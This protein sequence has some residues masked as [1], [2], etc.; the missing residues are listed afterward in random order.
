M[1]L[2]IQHLLE[3]PVGFFLLIIAIILLAPLLSER[4]RLPGVIGLIVGGII[5]GPYGLRLLDN[6]EVIQLF[7][8]IGLI[9]LMFSAGLE[10]DLAQFARVRNKAVSFGIFT[11]L[12][13]LVGGTLL[14]FAMGLTIPGAIL[15]GSAVSSHTLLAF[16]IL[17]RLGIV[18]RE[19]VA[20]TVGATVFT[21]IA[22][23]L[24][25]AIISGTA[26]GDASVARLIVLLISLAVYAAVVIF[27]LPRLGKQFFARFHGGSIEFQ[28]VLIALFGVAL[29]AEGIGL[30]AVVGAFLAGLAINATLPHRSIVVG[31][32]LFLGEALF[33]PIFLIHSGMI[34]NP[35][36]FFANGEALGVGIALTAVAYLTKYFAA[37]IG[38]RIYGYTPAE[39]M[40]MW[41]LSQAQAAVT[42]P[43]VIIGV[44]LGLFP[45]S[46]FSA[47]MLMILATSI[48]SPLLVE[49]FGKKM[50]APERST[51][52]D[53]PNPFERVLVPVLDADEQEQLLTLA[54][55]LAREKNGTLMPLHI[56]LAASGQ[57]IGKAH[58]TRVLDDEMINQPDTECQPLHRVDT[59]VARGILHSALENDASM[60]VMGWRGK[61]RF[62]ESIFGTTLDEVIWN[63]KAPVLI[64]RLPH[65]VNAIRQVVLVIASEST[66]LDFIDE[67]VEDSAI[68]A[69]ALKVP[70][71]I[72][73]EPGYVDL[74]KRWIRDLHIE[75]DHQI[76]PLVIDVVTAVSRLANEDTLVILATTG[77]R[78]RF[79]SS[80]G[81]LPETIASRTDSSL[82]ILHYPVAAAN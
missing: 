1:N 32:V 19:P 29:L 42:L 2:D 24:V 40:T 47:T 39:I 23:F 26:Q 30:H 13:P 7:A 71:L 81:T 80:L 62:T 53:R 78:Q 76:E 20:V 15:L 37:W 41:G 67:M 35:G 69:K 70:L 16:P 66:A 68:I 17:N 9:Y 12:I 4:L 72:L 77:S 38:G 73:S 61:K 46:V 58:G 56:S 18:G 21:D 10:V 51:P 74:E 44:E 36:A 25:L 14:G 60:I 22:A 8:E 57:V 49:R 59:Q 50:R 48:T 34:T 45:Q 5:V 75:H 79:R 52:T 6:G 54:G 43:T 27:G 55:I 11:F 82:M 64:G 28:F 65:P 3:S 31:R 63:T 33:I